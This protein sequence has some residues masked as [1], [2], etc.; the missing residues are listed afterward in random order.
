MSA[1]S[2]FETKAETDDG[3]LSEE[4]EETDIFSSGFSEERTLKDEMKETFSKATQ[5]EVA[6]NHEAKSDHRA[7]FSQ[8]FSVLQGEA[9]AGQRGEPGERERL[10]SSKA[11]AGRE[12]GEEEQVELGR[13]Q[14]VRDSYASVLRR[15]LHRY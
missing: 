2:E 6:F 13:A 4:F 12:S 7:I 8:I 10:A 1:Q 15:G 11:V 3:N 9:A 5:T 14:L